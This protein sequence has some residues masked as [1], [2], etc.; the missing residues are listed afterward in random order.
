MVEAKVCD[1]AEK[2]VDYTDTIHYACENAEKAAR[3]CRM[4]RAAYHVR[5]FG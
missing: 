4:G 2:A 5:N 1:S 3:A